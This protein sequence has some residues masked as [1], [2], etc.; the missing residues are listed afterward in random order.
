MC[1]LPLKVLMIQIKFIT[2]EVIFHPVKPEKFGE[3]FMCYFLTI[4]ISEMITLFQLK[5]NKIKSIFNNTPF[6]HG[7]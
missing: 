5:Q 2:N 1:F 7:H 4:Y 6:L 3:F